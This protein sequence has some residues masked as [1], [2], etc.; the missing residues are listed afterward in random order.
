MKML[1]AIIKTYGASDVLEVREVPKPVPHEGEILVK[2]HAAT[3]TAADS[4]MRR[5]DPCISRFF[6][7]FWKP[8]IPTPGTGFAGEVEA[9]GRNVTQFQPGDHIFGET[10]IKFSANAEYV[11]VDAEGVIAK[12]PAE[13]SFE[14]LATVTDGPLTSMNFLRNIVNVQPGQRILINGAAGSLGTAAVQLAKHFGAHVTGVCSAGNLEFVRSLGA[15]AVIDYGEED[16]TRSSA[17]YD[18]IYDTVGK[19]SF[20]RCKRVLAADGVYMAPVLSIPLLFQMLWTSK[21][22]RKKAKFS[23]TGL[24]PEADQKRLFAEV[25]ALMADGNLKVIIDRRFPLTEIAKAH[26]YVDTGHKRG[27]IVI[28]MD[29]LSYST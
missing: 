27:N 6:L 10:G 17:R 12:R 18:V 9:V 2:V 8:K 14:E 24:M 1:A 3:A 25:V 4:M 19:S 22:G 26:S 23:A 11:A 15:D 13:M 7:G 16:F 28:A 21:F 20:S 5:A 29:A